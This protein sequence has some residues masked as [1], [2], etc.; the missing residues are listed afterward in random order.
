MLR[1]QPRAARR[2]GFVILLSLSSLPP[3]RAQT[4]T[5]PGDDLTP[6][7]NLIRDGKNKEAVA[8]LKAVVKK[9]QGRAEAWFFLGVA[10]QRQDQLKDARKAFEKAVELQ[11]GHVAAR[12]GLSYLLLLH[13]ELPRAVAEAKEALAL[14]PRNAEAQY[15]IGAAR[16]REGDPS[17][18]LR[19]ADEAL[20]VNPDLAAALM[21]KAYA[22]TNLFA[23]RVSADL[24]RGRPS[25]G[26]DERSQREARRQKYALLKEAAECLG[27]A[28]Q[29]DPRPSVA[30][31]HRSELETLQF[32][33]RSAEDGVDSAE[34]ASTEGETGRPTITYKEKAKYT[35][36]A[37]DAGVAG[38]VM[39]MAMFTAEGEV[40]HILVLQGLSHGLT[41]E[42]IKAAQRIKFKPALKDGKPVSVRLILEFN[43][44]LY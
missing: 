35:D 7:I 8:A 29:L 11:P 4:V 2:F 32:Y 27:R 1:P 3:A 23:G 6:V 37:R 36:A 12:T 10:H 9:D 24:E 41:Q 19:Y 15:V 26:S 44:S 34:I 40:K 31:A 5:K 17:S 22:L 30:A 38:G 28:L 14:N 25:G 20:K 39:L 43:F 21:L 18:A 13:N 16:L 42:A 33:A